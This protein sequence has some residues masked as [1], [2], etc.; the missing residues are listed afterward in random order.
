MKQARESMFSMV[1]MD[2][3]AMNHD[4]AHVE[5]ITD[6][7]TLPIPSLRQKEEGNLSGLENKG[8]V[9]Q[10][11]K[12][13]ANKILKGQ[14]TIENGKLYDM[15]LIRAMYSTVWLKWWIAIIMKSCAGMSRSC[16]PV[17][18]YRYLPSC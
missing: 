9:K 7:D 17:N 8:L 11:G 15:S 5:T 12:K 3:L 6:E 4:T 1:G 2:V 10:Y 16:R 13:K 14:V 18:R